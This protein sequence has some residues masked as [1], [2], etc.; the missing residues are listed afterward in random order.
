MARMRTLTRA[1]VA[2]S[3][4]IS[5]L[6]ALTVWILTA[7][8]RG[9]F[10]GSN[11]VDTLWPQ[12]ANLEFVVSQFV[13][14]WI[15]SLVVLLWV[16]LSDR[17]RN[18][19]AL[20][21]DALESLMLAAPSGVILTDNR[22]HI[23][24]LNPVAARM[25]GVGPSIFDRSLD[26]LFER[27]DAPD[28]EA[29]IPLDTSPVQMTAITADG[30][31]FPVLIS[32]VALGNREDDLNATFVDQ[33]A[34]ELT[35]AKSQRHAERQFQALFNGV[36]DGVFRSL[37]D[38]TLISANPALIEMLGGDPAAGLADKND[39]RGF[40]VS[41]KQRRELMTELVRSG[42]V[43]NAVLHLNRCDGENIRVLANIRAV[44]D[45]DNRPILFEGTLTDLTGFDIKPSPESS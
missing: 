39:T 36:P 34:S 29:A 16:G 42:V 1:W 25:F 23:R 20:P 3:V 14:V 2:R 8:I 32:S 5:L 35:L 33:L 10:S 37:P 18:R 15:V 4:G 24:E 43:R 45:P 21:Q 44:R 6:M 12:S 38:G 28:G 17:R 9:A 7:L 26:E 19:R 41:S 13:A 22:R 11:I 27:P 31:R 40:H 30:E